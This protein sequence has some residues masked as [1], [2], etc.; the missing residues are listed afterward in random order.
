VNAK[1]VVEVSAVELVALAVEV[2]EIVAVV[3]VVVPLASVLE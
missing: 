3:V 1:V 2:D